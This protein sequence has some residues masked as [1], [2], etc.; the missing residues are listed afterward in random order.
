MATGGD[1]VWFATS[2]GVRE[3]KFSDYSDV[4]GILRAAKQLGAK[5]FVMR[6]G[7][8][9]MNQIPLWGVIQTR[10]HAWQGRFTALNRPVRVFAEEEPDAALMFAIAKQAGDE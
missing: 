1:P 6:E 3:F 4:E 8:D 5:Y 2:S 9:Y 7:F 10:G